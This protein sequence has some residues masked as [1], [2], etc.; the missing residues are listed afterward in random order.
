[1]LKEWV[2]L[3]DDPVEIR[4]IALRLM[5][6]ITIISPSG[7][8][9]KLYTP[10]MLDKMKESIRHYAPEASEEE[11]SEM[12]LK[13]IYDYWVFGCTV[14]EEFYL[15]LKDKNDTEKREYM[16]SKMRSVY[17]RH[18]NWDAGDER[19][20]LLEDKY[21]LYK[22]LQPFYKREIIEISSMDDYQFFVNFTRKHKEFV[23]KPANFAFGI[24]VHKVSMD[25]Y[26]YDYKMA[27]E[28]I[29]DEGKAIH[30]KHPSKV[31]KMVLEELIIQD[32]S[33][34]ILH[35]GSVN[36]IRATAVKG[37]D[38]K[39]HIYH[40]WI[41]VGFGGEFV[42][43]AALN[44]FDAE[45]DPVTGIVISDGYQESGKIFTVHPDSGIK[46]KGFQ[47]P[48]WNELIVFID[49]IMAALP[50]YK[51]VGWD[52]VL[53]PDGWCV[54]EGNYSGEFMFQLI[55]NKGYKKEFEELIGWKYDKQFW[56]EDMKEFSDM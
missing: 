40:P 6:E 8:K 50:K 13:F 56:W 37:Y 29:L 44:G 30:K 28:H 51:Y 14:D 26:D 23:V 2:K 54:M 45:I 25:D 41:K 48:K 31:S 10:L 53:T 38:G 42:A 17:V 34:A 3:T 49:K 12:C 27:I 20:I 7:E 55:N 46:I 43:S 36:A 4:D 18:L 11:C 39:I 35:H 22:M 15:H 32:E 16:V 52:L 5:K 24:G 21:R 33:L 1:M 9:K 19:V 47:I